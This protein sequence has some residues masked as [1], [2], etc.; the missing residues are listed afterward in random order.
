ML[1]AISVGLP[2]VGFASGAMQELL[3]WQTDLLALVSDD[4]FQRYENFDAAKL[5][6]K[7]SLCCQNLMF[8]R[9][10]ALAHSHLYSF[11]ECGRR[12]VEVLT[13]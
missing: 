3:T 11:N 2:V 8:F 1:E 6:D 5:A 9:E 13:S 10:R 4:V 7:I 12:Y